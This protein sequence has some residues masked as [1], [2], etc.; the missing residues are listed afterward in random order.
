MTNGQKV[1]FEYHGNRYTFTVNQAA[2]EGQEKSNGV[3]RGMIS[4]DTYIIFEAAGSSGIKVS[5][6]ALGSQAI[7]YHSDC[8]YIK[9]MM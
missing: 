4:A 1:I 2:V 5:I 7:W 9:K 6:F 8:I 3:E